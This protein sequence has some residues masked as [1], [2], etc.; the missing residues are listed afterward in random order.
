MIGRTT[1]LIPKFLVTESGYSGAKETTWLER[2]KRD[3]LYTYC[4]ITIEINQRDSNDKANS[5]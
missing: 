4:S 1:S 2:E 5:P 3:Q